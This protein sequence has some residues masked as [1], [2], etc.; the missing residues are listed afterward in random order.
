MNHM[1]TSVNPTKVK[2]FY[3]PDYEDPNQKD[4]MVIIFSFVFKFVYNIEIL[5]SLSNLDDFLKK[6]L[7]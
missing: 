3:F 5:K 1:S 7:L 4:D 6:V 2:F